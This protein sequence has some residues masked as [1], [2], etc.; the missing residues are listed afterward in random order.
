MAYTRVTV[1]QFQARFPIFADKDSDYVQAMLTESELD[2]DDS[3]VSQAN[4]TAG[5]MYLT[6]HKIATDNSQEGE[7]V[8]VGSSAGGVASES[9]GGMSISYDNSASSGEGSA[10]ASRWG[11]TEYGRR[12]YD[13]VLKNKPAI[14]SI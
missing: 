2:V 9:F 8:T 7:V 5:I 11:S 12:F 4:Y 14:V 1:E 6:A 3:W 10:S 13:L